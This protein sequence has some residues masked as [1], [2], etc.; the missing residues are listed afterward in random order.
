M[1][2]IRT[3]HRIQITSIGAHRHLHHTQWLTT[4]DK[5]SLLQHT[6]EGYKVYKLEHIHRNKYYYSKKEFMTKELE[7]YDNYIYVTPTISEMNKMVYHVDQTQSVSLDDMTSIRRHM[8]S[9]FYQTRAAINKHISRVTSKI[10]RSPT[11]IQLNNPAP[12]YN[13]EQP[14]LEEQY[15]NYREW[16]NRNRPIVPYTPSHN[17]ATLNFGV[18]P[19][20]D[21]TPEIEEF[22]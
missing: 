22:F 7:F 21:I 10:H 15:F 18:L 9:S 13:Y 12:R 1:S 5:S 8:K 20:G 3:S 16:W 17:I 11:V 6:T 2:T 14:Y 19:T 4:I